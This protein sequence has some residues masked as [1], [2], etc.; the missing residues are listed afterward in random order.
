MT[1]RCILVS[2]LQK[3][4]G[5]V[6]AVAGISFDVDYRRV[7]GFLGPN[8]AGKTTTIRVLTTLLPPTSGRVEI[9]GKDII[10]HSKEIKRRIGVVLQ[11]PS[12]ESNLTVEKAL[13]LYG[14]L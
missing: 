6:Q 3:K 1:E 7:F 2:D 14:R 5:S 4:Y 9:F 13:D 11:E 10:R 12:H 8:G